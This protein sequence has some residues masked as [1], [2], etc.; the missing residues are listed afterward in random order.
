MSEPSNIDEEE[1]LR[2][3]TRI[4]QL[5]EFLQRGY[6]IL[7]SEGDPDFPEGVKLPIPASWKREIQKCI[8]ILHQKR[9]KALQG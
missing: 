4:R 1:V 7:F 2:T 8:K 6:F 3:T 5:K 9:L